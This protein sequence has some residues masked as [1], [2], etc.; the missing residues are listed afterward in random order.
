[1]N[2]IQIFEHELF[3]TVRTVRTNGKILFC[4]KDVASA[5]G[6]S[7]PT[8]A[9]TT[10]CKGVSKMGIPTKGGKQNLN[11]IPEGDIYRLVVS[12]KLPEAERFENLMKLFLR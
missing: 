10:H 7:N 11:F 4:G 12:S 8:K 6:Y 1:M 5:L 3:G 2:K 9:V